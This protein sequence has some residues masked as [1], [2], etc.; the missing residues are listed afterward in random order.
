MTLKKP[1]N[2]Q[3]SSVRRVR[4]G[5]ESK[6]FSSCT[7]CAELCSDLCYDIDKNVDISFYVQIILY[8]VYTFQKCVNKCYEN[9]N[10]LFDFLLVM[11]Y[12]FRTSN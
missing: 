7:K 5:T 2:G 11:I 10:G 1:E 12:I 4:T 9:M 3:K 6:V 8:Y